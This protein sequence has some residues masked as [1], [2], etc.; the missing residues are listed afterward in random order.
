M[1]PITAAQIADAAGGTIIAGDAG[2]FA[3]SVSTDSRTVSKECVF[4]ALRGDNFD[5][6]AYVNDVAQSGVTVAVVD[7]DVA[8]PAGVTLVRVPDT[9]RALG[10]LASV[11]RRSITRPKV[12]AIAGSNG[13][14]STKNTLH[15]VLSQALRGSASPK[16][17]NNDIGV[18]ATLFPVSPDDDYV[19]LEIGTNHPG[20]VEYLSRMSEPDIA[21]ITSIGEEHLE[22]FGSLDAVRD[23]NAAITRGLRE[24]GLLVACDD[25]GL[26]QRLQFE[27]KTL[28]FGDDSFLR[29]TNIRV[30][31]EGTSF[32]VAGERFSL[33]AIGAHFARNALAIIAVARHMGLSDEQIQKGLAAADASDMRMQ[34]REHAGVTVLND[35]YNANPTSMLAAIETLQHLEWRGRKIAVVG[36]MKELGEHSSEAHDRMANALAAAKFDAVFAVGAAWRAPAER[37]GATWLPDADAAAPQVVVDTRPGDLVLLKGSRSMKLERVADALAARP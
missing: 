8:A 35:A 7:R 32:E 17:F 34:R 6:H 37:I 29:A 1:K 27:G 30:T 3:N 9:R 25:S 20:E 15:A 2:V 16:S 31:L 22:F 23:E 33:P 36:D 5:G 12:I 21:V 26:S 11:V 28:R 19:I 13:K 24:A 4:V 10:R 14:T 18:P